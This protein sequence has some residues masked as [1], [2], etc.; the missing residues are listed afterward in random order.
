MSWLRQLVISPLNAGTGFLVSTSVFPCQ[1]HSK[2]PY[3]Y[4]VHAMTL[5]NPSNWH[6]CSIKHLSMCA[7]TMEAWVQSQDNP[8]S[9]FGGQVTLWQVLL[10]VLQVSIIEII[11][12]VLYIYISFICQ[13][14]CIIL[15]N[16]SIFNSN[17]PRF[18]SYMNVMQYWVYTQLL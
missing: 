1:D 12:L 3:F 6:S 7:I 15:A 14:C 17:T 13:W 10:W 8:C 5:S 11:L 2:A 18:L 4:F 9:I 16:D